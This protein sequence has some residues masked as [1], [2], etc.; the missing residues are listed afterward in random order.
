[1]K[2][3]RIILWLAGALF[4]SG[5]ATWVLGGAALTRSLGIWLWLGSL[6]VLALPLVLLVIDMVVQGIRRRL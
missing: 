5:F 3:D 1:M 6:G 4:A 2:P